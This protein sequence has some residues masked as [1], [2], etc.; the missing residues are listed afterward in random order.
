MAGKGTVLPPP[1]AGSRPK[2]GKTSNMNFVYIIKNEKGRYYVGS[3]ANIEKRLYYHNSGKNRSTKGKGPWK[4][5]YKEEY[6]DKQNAVKR[7]KQIKS[8]KGG[9]AFKKLLENS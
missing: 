8:F 7:E 3:T 1:L 2:A 4:L 6:S 9:E 5:V